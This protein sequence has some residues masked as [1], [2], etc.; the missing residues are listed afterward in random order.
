MKRLIRGD[1]KLRAFNPFPARD[2][3]RSRREGFGRDLAAEFL[4]MDRVR[5][6]D[7]GAI[8]ENGN[9]GIVQHAA[10]DA[11]D[12]RDLLILVGDERRPI[13]TRARDVPAETAGILEF[14]RE[15]AGIDQELL[16]DAAAHHA[17][18]AKLVVLGDG[19]ARSHLRGDPR[20]AHAAR[21]R[22]DDEE[23]EVEF[24]H[25]H[26]RSST[27]TPPGPASTRAEAIPTNNRGRLHRE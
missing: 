11:R 2:N 20:G 6:L 22:A 18:A 23:I 3:R 4:E 10:I 1:A 24:V 26:F 5:V 8:L 14:F 27:R 12:A 25:H 15:R 21:T 19:D 7:E 16:G 17:G 9:A 13:E